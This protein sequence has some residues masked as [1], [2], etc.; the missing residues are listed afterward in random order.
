MAGVSK[1]GSI[2]EK[3]EANIR[4]H[5][6]KD[7]SY[8]AK[9]C[10]PKFRAPHVQ[11]VRDKIG[12]QRDP[13]KGVTVNDKVTVIGGSKSKQQTA[14]SIPVEQFIRDNDL[15]HKT[16]V[17]IDNLGDCLIS[18]LD[19]LNQLRKDPHLKISSTHWKLLK[20]RDDFQKYQVVVRN[21]LYW[22]QP[23][24]I[25]KLKIELDYI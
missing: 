24:I 14:G 9:L 19:L 15:K 23:N 21:T 11:A 12:V 5:P 22:A 25:E 16:K 6:N 20:E 7:N 1:Y 13:N 18:D 4:R 10:G 3:I 2:E 8:I 17:A